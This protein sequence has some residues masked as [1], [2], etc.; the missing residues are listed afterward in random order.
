MRL[1]KNDFFRQV[2]DAEARGASA[3]ELTALLGRGRAKKGIFEGDL[4]HGELEIGQVSSMI[5]S[6]DSVSVIMER[7]L[8][9]A[10]ETQLRLNLPLF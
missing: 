1:I 10:R 4:Q 2:A 6:V 8:R 3:E 9:E 7:L 5:R